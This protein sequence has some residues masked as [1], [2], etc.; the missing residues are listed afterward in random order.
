[1]EPRYA[2][3][4]EDDRLRPDHGARGEP[5]GS[6]P[7][8]GRGRA[9]PPRGVDAPGRPRPPL[10]RP[11]GFLHEGHLSLVRHARERCDAVV[12]SL[13]V[14]PTQFSVAEDFGVYPSDRAGDLAKLREAGC[15]VAF[16]PPTLYHETAGS[17]GEAGNL[18]GAGPGGPPPPPPPPPRGAGAPP[19][20]PPPPRPPPPG[21]HETWVEV[22]RL[23]R[24]LCGGSRPHFFRGVATVVA[25][26][27]HIVEPDVAVFGRKDY[28]Q[29]RLVERMARDLD[30]GVEVVGLP[31]VREADGLAMSS[32]NARLAPGDRERAAGVSRALRW[33]AGAIAA[34]EVGDAG[35]AARGVAERVAA[36]GGRVDYVEVRDARELTEVPAAIAPGRE[37]V[38]A[39]AAHFGDVRLIDNIDCQAPARA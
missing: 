13:Y 12:A 19:P 9:P 2:Q 32:R 15:D 37:V 28:Q 16:C 35:A 6:L 11:Q 22:T 21:A 24:G 33:A 8:A 27:F 18:A 38:V 1:V 26:L 30:F 4:G 10:P 25:K 20:R 14:N 7:R 5:D 39:V 31:T 34:G 3:G 23:Q 29:F 36:S 17:A